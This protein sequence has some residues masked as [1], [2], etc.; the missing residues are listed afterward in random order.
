MKEIHKVREEFYRKTRGKN[1]DYILKLIKKGSKE[2]TQELDATE[3][4]L[5]LI[6]KE[7]YMIPQLDS[8]EDIH[9]VGEREGK[10]GRRLPKKGQ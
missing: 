8:V 4:D 7:K 3:S 2:V 9:Q 6:Q 5:K 10:Y 1:R